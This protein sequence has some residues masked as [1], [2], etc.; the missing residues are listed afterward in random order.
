MRS[1]SLKAGDT[2]THR[3]SLIAVISD[4]TFLCPTGGTGLVIP[5]NK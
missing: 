2:H 5:L 1:D 3:R 4:L